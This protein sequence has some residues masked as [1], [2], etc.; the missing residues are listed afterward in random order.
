MKPL[1]PTRGTGKPFGFLIAMA[2][3]S[4]AVL[5]A[6]GRHP[7]LPVDAA[8]IVCSFLPLRVPGAAFDAMVPM[9]AG[10]MGPL[11]WQ[12]AVLRNYVYAPEPTSEDGEFSDDN[13]IAR[14]EGAAVNVLN[15]V[16]M[17]SVTSRVTLLSIF[18]PPVT[19]GLGQYRQ[20]RL[21]AMGL[22]RLQY[23]IGGHDAQ[24]KGVRS[25]ALLA[26]M[27]DLQELLVWLDY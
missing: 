21:A 23:H 15:L 10:Y 26:D 27:D 18:R 11:Q 20:N 5:L 4:R 19:S 3:V 1:V 17:G 9:Y 22:R 12:C 13:Y 7:L 16:G 6:G 8:E 2:G 14:L 24:F 25:A